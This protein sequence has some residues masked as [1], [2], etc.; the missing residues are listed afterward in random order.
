MKRAIALTLAAAFFL[1]ALLWLPQSSAAI[2][3]ADICYNDWEVCR[4]RAFQSD[5][6]IVKTTLW[7]T[8]CD[9]ALGKCLLG[10]TRI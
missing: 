4:S 7:L 9:V 3:R 5:E 6:G 10:F 1:S 8:V 2:T